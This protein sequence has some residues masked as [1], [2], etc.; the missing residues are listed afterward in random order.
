MTRHERDDECAACCQHFFRRGRLSCVDNIAYL[1][2]RSG[3]ASST[4]EQ[5]EPTTEVYTASITCSDSQQAQGQQHPYQYHFDVLSEE[6]IP[7]KGCVL[8]N[9]RAF[10]MRR[11]ASEKDKRAVFWMDTLPFCEQ[12]GANLCCLRFQ[13]ETKPAFCA[14]NPKC[15]NPPRPRPCEAVPQELGVS[16]RPTTTNHTGVPESTACEHDEAS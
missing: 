13:P 10:M 2:S 11:M 15:K 5:A 12:S 4:Q 16:A 9:L 1:S 8:W 7:L 3:P 14:V 6:S